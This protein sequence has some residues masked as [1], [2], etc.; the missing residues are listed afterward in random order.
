M[1]YKLS[2]EENGHGI[3]ITLSG[4]VKGEEIFRLNE[5]FMSDESYPQW[6]Y[7]IWDFSNIADIDVTFDQLR[8]YAIQDSIASR[9]NPNQRIAIIPRKKSQGGL[10]SIFHVYEEVWGGYESKSFR[11]VDA[12]RQWAQSG[13]KKHSQET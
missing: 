5:Q 11:D 6:R 4:L 8:S 3:V 10:D 9:I 13:Q 7:Q 1:P 12:A 2:I